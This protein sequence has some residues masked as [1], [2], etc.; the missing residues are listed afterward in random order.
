MKRQLMFAA[1]AGVLASACASTP[2]P[3]TAEWIDWRKDRLLRDFARSH[4]GDI[5]TVREFSSAFSGDERKPSV[6]EL[7][8]LAPR[9]IVLVGEFA[10]AAEPEVRS[11]YQQCGTGPRTS[12]LFADLLR[13][14]GVDDDVV[15]AIEDM[16]LML[17]GNI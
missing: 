2:E 10:K 16:G 3:C 1:L 11:V 4:L 6:L 15:A 9:M 7:A 17:D 13:R 5:R 8:Q 12:Q 14:E